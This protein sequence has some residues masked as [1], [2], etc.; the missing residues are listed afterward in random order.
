MDTLQT[1]LTL[2][3][4]TFSLYEQEFIVYLQYKCLCEEATQPIKKWINVFQK[5]EDRLKRESEL[6]NLKRTWIELWKGEIEKNLHFIKKIESNS[7][8]EK[9]FEDYF[10]K[11]DDIKKLIFLTQAI[12]INAYFEFSS[13]E[14][15]YYFF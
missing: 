1:D 10:S 7:K 6:Q 12:S 14:K 8:A 5:E 15:K 13:K 2:K 11:I 3:S 4:F 9:E